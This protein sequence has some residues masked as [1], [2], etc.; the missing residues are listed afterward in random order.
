MLLMLL[1]VLMLLMVPTVEKRKEGKGVV[2]RPV[3]PPVQNILRR[4]LN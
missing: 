3:P 1:T 4:V 2:H